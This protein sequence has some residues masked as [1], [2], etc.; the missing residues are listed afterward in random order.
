[1]LTSSSHGGPDLSDLELVSHILQHPGDFE[2]LDNRYRPFIYRFC[3]KRIKHHETAEDLAQE[4]M[5]KAYL[6]LDTYEGRSQL[7]TWLCSI[8]FNEF[9]MFLRRTKDKEY[10]AIDDM[11]LRSPRM[12]TVDPAVNGISSRL[13][14]NRLLPMV[15]RGQLQIFVLH[16]IMGY[17]HIEIASLIPCSVGNSKSQLHKA[18]LKLSAEAAKL[19]GLDPETVRYWNLEQIRSWLQKIISNRPSGS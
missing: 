8:A 12:A 2:I 5:L 18:R 6:K 15:P 9:R 16:D 7:R 19:Q 11:I 17:E 14:L 4:T 10:A 3:L 13:L 1:M